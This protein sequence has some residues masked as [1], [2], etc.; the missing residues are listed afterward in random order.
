MTALLATRCGDQRCSADQP[1]RLGAMLRCRSAVGGERTTLV[2]PL[3]NMAP[4]S[5][6]WPQLIPAWARSQ[7]RCFAR[8]ADDEALPARLLATA[9]IGLRR[10][11]VGHRALAALLRRPAPCDAGRASASRP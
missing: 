10:L 11:G 6:P 4:P 2:G 3:C 7:P 1:A 9:E 8:L 5:R